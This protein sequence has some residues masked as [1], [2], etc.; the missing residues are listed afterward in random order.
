MSSQFSTLSQ[1][2]AAGPRTYGGEI[3]YVSSA[4]GKEARTSDSSYPVRGETKL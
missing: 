3:G 2:N 4:D 1:T